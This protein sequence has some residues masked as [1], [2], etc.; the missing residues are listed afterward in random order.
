MNIKNTR[1][2]YGLINIGIHWLTAGL[3]AVLFPLGLIMV[4]LGY[5]D[6]GYK[7]YP[8]IHK[9]LGLILFALTVL[10]MLWVFVV[11][12]PP[13]A[14]PQA[15]ILELLAKSAHHLMYLCLLILLVSGYLISTADG[16]GIDVF[17][18]FSVPALFE[19]FKG[20]ADLAGNIHA[21]AA[22]SLMGLIVLHVAGALKHHV[23]DKDRT[24]KRIFG[25]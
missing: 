9:S 13:Q 17:N 20:Q 25:R 2:H 12:K 6:A 8:H 15:R 7:S 4:D 21:I 5:Y 3:I 1:T 22:W 16:R 18:W 11:S 14:L 23:V 10:R 19:P 24:L